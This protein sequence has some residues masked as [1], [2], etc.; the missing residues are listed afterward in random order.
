MSHAWVTVGFLTG[1]AAALLPPLA[2][3]V[4][5]VEGEVPLGTKDLDLTAELLPLARPPPLLP[6]LPPFY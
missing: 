6:L 4:E 1:A 5:R 3:A 2:G